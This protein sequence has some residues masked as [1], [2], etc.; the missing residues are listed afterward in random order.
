MDFDIDSWF[1]IFSDARTAPNQ[2]K[3]FRVLQQITDTLKNDFDVDDGQPAELQQP[4]YSRPLGPDDMTEAQLR[5]LNLIDWV[6]VQRKPQPASE[7]II[8]SINT[9]TRSHNIFVMLP[10]RFIDNASGGR[11]A[12]TQNRPIY[13][14]AG[15][16][17]N[18][19]CF[20]SF[21]PFNVLV[22]NTWIIKMCLNQLIFTLVFILESDNTISLLLNLFS[23]IK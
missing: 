20:L 14:D 6:P 17:N 3:S 2:S 10:F 15:L 4:Q 23:N 16:W 5:K 8:I 9:Y 1:V 18:A 21:S 11:Y 19:H 7:F 12:P 13:Q 22:K